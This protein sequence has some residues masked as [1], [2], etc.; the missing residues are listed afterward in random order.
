[1]KNS[2]YIHCDELNRIPK[3]NK[4][5]WL[6]EIKLLSND[7]FENSTVLQV[8]CMDGTRIVNLLRVRPDLKITGL[9][10]EKKFLV[11]A[12]DK[13]EKEGLSA[14]LVEGDITKTLPLKKFDYVLCLNNTLG[15]IKEY[16]K[17]FEKMKALGKRV[18]ISV[19]GERFT[20]GLAVS[21]FNS[22]GLKVKEIKNNII[23]TDDFGNIKRFSCE[24]VK[25]WMGVVLD[26]PLG[27]YCKIG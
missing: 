25:S 19:Y 10:I 4:D 26:T 5:N 22:L 7:L 27:Y 14:E 15:Y 2:F 6:T 20:D 3:M 11:I 23:H 13:L 16:V 18:I 21:Y 17:A 8:G 9:D 1:M 24:E 12:K